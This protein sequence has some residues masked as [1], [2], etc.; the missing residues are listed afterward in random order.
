MV[1]E[2]GSADDRGSFRAAVARSVDDVVKDVGGEAASK[3]KARD[4]K[5]AIA[6]FPVIQVDEKQEDHVDGTAS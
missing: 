3:A 4:L 5:S 2:L 1:G 6:K